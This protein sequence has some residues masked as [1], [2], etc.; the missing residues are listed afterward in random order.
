MDTSLLI[1][2]LLVA[3]VAL[4]ALVMLQRQRSQKLKERFGPEYDHALD[5]Y[6]NKR[7]AEVELA[8]R[9][10]RVETLHIRP[11]S[12]EERNRFADAWREVQA[13]FVDDP[14]GAIVDAD[15]LVKQVMET[16]GYPMGDFE[17]RAADISVDHPAVVTNYRTARDIALEN[18]NGKADTEK[19]R[20]A[21]VQYR[22]LFEDLLETAEQPV[23][24]TME[25]AR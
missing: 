8:A 13:R 19:L 18:R 7:R 4:I 2:L 10:K 23:E 22:A 14:S 3:I 20:Q 6:G 24:K 21:M 16:R 11:L 9:Q 17:Q 25:V 12:S 15:Q 5:E 1:V